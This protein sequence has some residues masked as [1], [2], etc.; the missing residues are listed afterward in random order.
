MGANGIGDRATQ[1]KQQS[2]VAKLNIAQA[3][4]E[5]RVVAVD[6]S[7]TGGID[8][9]KNYFRANNVYDLALLPD[10]WD[11]NIPGVD[12]NPN[13]GGL[14]LGR[15]WGSGGIL[16]TPATP[17]VNTNPQLATN[18]TITGTYDSTNSTSFTVSIDGVTYT[19][20]SSPELTTVGDQWSL[21]LSAGVQVLDFETTYSVVATSNGTIVDITSNEITTVSA[22]EEIVVDSATTLQIWYDGSDITQFQP[23][24]PNDGQ[25]ITQWNDKSNFAHNANPVGGA[26]FRPTYETAELNGLSVVQFDGIDDTL[27]INPFSQ[28]ANATN[29][30]LFFVAKLDSIGAVQSLGS[31]NTDDLKIC[32][33]GTNWVV[34]NAKGTGSSII[35]GDAT[36]Y[37]I[38]TLTY[39]GTTATN[40]DRLKFRYDR[41]DQV[42][43]F[44]ATIVGSSTSG[45]G[46]TYYVGGRGS[47]AEPFHGKIAEVLM[48]RKTLS[49]TEITNVEQYLN[50]HWALGL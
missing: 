49:L 37:H 24:N 44:G 6:G 41:N 29:I 47:G 8:A 27:S 43:N 10:V 16:P 50:D 36:N 38:F 3:K 4:R 23:T 19:L 45:S 12:N 48:F 1:T 35:T 22:I 13:V 34:L 25:G 26:T 30:T 42:L 20:G 18:G 40:T 9:T 28:I 7:I 5:G 32:H 31:S 17:T 39:D 33:D 21:D 46:G 11:G 2:Q 15:P 14:Q